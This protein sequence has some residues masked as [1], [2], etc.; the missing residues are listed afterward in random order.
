VVHMVDIGVL[1]LGEVL[2]ISSWGGVYYVQTTISWQGRGGGGAAVWVWT[3]GK[4][5]GEKYIWILVCIVY[6]GMESWC[7]YMSLR[8]CCGCGS[9]LWHVV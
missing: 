8:S 2:G 7:T 4:M 3:C 5:R 6:G 9:S 1:L